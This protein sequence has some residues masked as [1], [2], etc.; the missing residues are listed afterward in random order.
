M[1][2]Y[3]VWINGV[4]E[5]FLP[6]SDR[7]LA[8]GDGLFET[9]RV[10]SG[11]PTLAD[12]HW[13]RLLRSCE[14]LGIVLDIERLLE[15]VDAF[16]FDNQVGA[17][18]LKVI[19][20]RGSGGRGYSPE[21]CLSPRRILSLHPLPSRSRDPGL[22]GARVKLCRMRLGRSVL[23]G[24]KHLNRLEQVLA[25]GEWRG[26]AYDEGLLC[27]VEGNLIE[28]TMSNL[29]IVTHDGGLV[30]PDLSFSGV[31]GVC[32]DFIIEFARHRGI[33]VSEQ[34]VSPD[35]EGSE[36]FLCN[37]VNGVWPVIEYEGRE[38]GVGSLTAQIRDCVLEELNA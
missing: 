17:A 20:T 18:V 31:A 16:L 10:S 23:A 34:R 1:S 32:R 30:T 12:Y 35:L 38:W 11:K 15:E 22:H 13:R 4:P 2:D 9:V 26:G 33:A 27:D 29:F 19:I 6:V 3:P 36:I 25:S 5:G 14:Q 7:G 28:G 21:D 24:L 8:Y 37:S